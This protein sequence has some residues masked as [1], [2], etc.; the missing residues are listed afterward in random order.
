MFDRFTAR[1]LRVLFHARSQASELGAT[2][3]E[4]EHIL[5]GVLH[6]GEGIGNGILARSVDLQILRNDIV[7]RVNGHQQVPKSDEIPFSDSCQHALEYALE[8]AE[9]LSH[10][11]V[12]TEHL[13][14]GV[15]REED[16]V[17]AEV[18]RARGLTFEGL[19]EAIV[20]LCVADE[21]EPP[22]PPST[23]ANTY[24]WPQIPFVPSRTIHILHSGMQ[25]PTQPVIN[26]AGTVFSAYGFTLEEIIVRAWA[27]S[28]WYVDIA[29]DRCDH[30]RFDFLMVLPQ[31]E[32]WETCLGLLRSAIEQQFA[33]HVSRETRMRDVYRLTDTGRRGRMLRRYPDPPPGTGFSSLAF[34]V[35][36]RRSKDTPMFPIE[37][38][39]VHSVPFMFLVHWFEKILGRQVIDQ[40][41]LPG[42]YGFELK[43]RVSTPEAFIRLLRNEAGLVMA[44]VQRELPT[45]IVT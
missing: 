9:R 15:L 10:S 34:S 11:P 18:L 31:E 2:A 25:W 44:P 20:E 27:G 45:L 13:L 29:R 26:H 14:L 30:E 21:P 28:R 1:A 8:E 12:G 3:I 41:D 39:A 43:E 42:I 22:G 16:S 36:M 33:V 38:F 19:R 24:K 17:A 7:G 23:P 4:P 5:L 32:T 37:P 40:T 35:F 6:E